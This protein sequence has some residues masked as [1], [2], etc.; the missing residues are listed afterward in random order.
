MFSRIVNTCR[1][2]IGTLVALIEFDMVLSTAALIAGGLAATGGAVGSALNR[3]RAREEETANYQRARDYLTSMYYRDPLS[4][5]SNR[6][7]LKTVRENYAD[8]L[9]ALN[10]RMVAGGATME[11]ALAARQAQNESLDKVYS[12]LLMGEDARRDKIDAQRMALDDR[13]SQAVQSGYREAAQ[14]WQTWGSQMAS[15]AMSYGSSQL[16]GGELSAGEW[17]KT[18]PDGDALAGMA[19][20]VD[21]EDNPILQPVVSDRRLKNEPKYVTTPALGGLHGV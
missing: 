7:L 8:N 11:N 3:A 1:I 6:A 4:T 2:P 5:A 10:N 16:L 9:D 21:N 13:H 15:A 20:R 18:A 17:A 14:D 19:A 12:Q